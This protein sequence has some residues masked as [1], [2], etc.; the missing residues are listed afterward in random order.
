MGSPTKK[1]RYLRM[2][3]CAGLLLGLNLSFVPP[4]AEGLYIPQTGDIV[5]HTSQS[6][7]SD[8]IRYGTFSRFT[9][10]GV[11]VVRK[12]RPYV[13]EA[14]ATARYTPLDE[15]L[16]RGDGGN[17]RIVRYRSG[18]SDIQ[19]KQLELGLA[20]HMGK[21]YDS[22]F[23]WSDSKMYCSELVWKAYHRAGIEISAPKTFKSF[24]GVHIPPIKRAMEKRWSGHL[25]L[26]E[27]VVAPVDVMKGRDFIVVDR[28]GL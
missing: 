13:A 2:I 5:G 23:Q 19:K 9:H 24:P 6:G 11:V 20:S 8:M 26:D 4:R 21:P 15:W 22:A 12:G 28:K 16:A 7:Q 10:V 3:F 25:D 14:V 27:T 17:Y 18:L 1:Q